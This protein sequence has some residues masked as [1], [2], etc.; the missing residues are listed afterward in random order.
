MPATTIPLCPAQQDA[1][2]G[3]LMDADLEFIEPHTRA[4]WRLLNHGD[5]FSD[6]RCIDVNEKKLLDRSLVRGE[7]AV[8]RWA[9]AW[10]G[11]GNCF[12][13]RNPRG[14]SGNPCR[15]TTFSLDID[16]IRP[17]GAAATGLQNQDALEAGRAVLLHCGNNG[18]LGNSGNGSLV[19][20]RLRTPVDDLKD[21]ESRLRAWEE[22]LRRG[23]LAPFAGKVRL[24]ATFDSAR[25][26]KCVGTASTKGDR[27]HWRVAR[28]MDLPS[29]PYRVVPG[30]PGLPTEESRPIAA[31]GGRPAVVPLHAQDF[32][33]ALRCKREGLEPAEALAALGRGWARPVDIGTLDGKLRLASGAL[34]RLAPE[35]REEYDSWLKV[36]LALRDLG[37]IGLQLWDSWSRESAKYEQGI[38][39]AKWA[40]FEGDPKIT[41]GSLE[42]WAR[43]D[44]KKTVETAYGR[45]LAISETVLGKP[46]EIRTLADRADEYL[47]HLEGRG[48]AGT[49]GLQTGFKTLDALLG[50]C[51]AGEFL[52]VASRTGL[53]KTSFVCTVTGG[54]VASG[55]RVAL[56]CTEMDWQ[57][58]TNRVIAAFHGISASGVDRGGMDG[59]DSAVREFLSGP[60]QQLLVDDAPVATIDYVRTVC[61]QFKPDVVIYDHVQ[62]A[63]DDPSNSRQQI[64]GFV[65]KFK[66]LMRES[67][68]TGILLSQIRRLGKDAK[69]RAFEPSLSDLKE[70]GT[71]EEEA[72]AVM[73]LHWP[74]DKPEGRYVPVVANLA[75]NRYGHT[76]YF[77]LVFD[78]ETTRFLERMPT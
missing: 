23:V 78:R 18:Y 30:L 56:F 8:V 77:E 66:N 64:S 48:K 36:G 25:I 57:S 34:A 31:S 76:D 17:I 54:L 65:K 15:V 42:H 71:I 52:V 63:G 2:R 32:A 38:C 9:S 51:R 69:G 41:V 28:F 53:G 49:A 27:A 59:R 35:R 55:K 13:G 58:L 33:V 61:L 12:I 60:G 39:E 43:D 74:T 73:L 75:K 10:N 29:P 50:G 68:A 16:P 22:S 6:L 67:G 62:R 44:Q 7:E 40:T 19:L 1:E 20:F 70:S 4:L 24:D 26:I 14:A 21:F 5:D 3:G 72:A 45:P 11:R 37:L 46:A 47:R